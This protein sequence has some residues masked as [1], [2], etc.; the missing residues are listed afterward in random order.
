M[1]ISDYLDSLLIVFLDVDT[2]DQAIDSLIDALENEGHLP[3]KEVF[4]KAIFDREELISTGIGMGVAVPHAK[5][6]EF[7][8]FFIAIGIQKKK[9]A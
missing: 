1:R 4:R 7:S 9:G 8:D 6:K 2:R 5:L 3:R